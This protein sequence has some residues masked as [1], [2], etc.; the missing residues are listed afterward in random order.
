MIHRPSQDFIANAIGVINSKKLINNFMR[1][2]SFF[3]SKKNQNN[4][5]SIDLT[6]FMFV[7]STHSKYEAGVE[8]ASVESCWKGIQINKNS[9]HEN[10]YS[11]TIKRLDKQKNNWEND[12]QMSIKKMK[13]GAVSNNKLELWGY[14]DDAM[15]VSFSDYGI[16]ILFENNTIVKIILKFFYR[17][18]ELHYSK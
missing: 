3:K 2:L 1:M 12:V 7:S 6:N 16:A 17:N 9:N 14:G 18:V 10:S 4:E 8:K 11:M 13:I 5:L 15:G